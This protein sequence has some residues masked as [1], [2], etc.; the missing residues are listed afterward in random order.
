MTTNMYRIYFKRFVDIVGA[1]VTIV[2]LFPIFL[3]IIALIKI[4]DPGP[5]IFIQRR[6]GKA[7]KVFEFYKFRSM[8]ENIG[9]FP[10]DK[11]GDIK[12]TW[13][14]KLIRRTSI[15]ELPQLINI[16]KGDMSIIGPRPPIPKQEELIELRRLNGALNCR[17]GLTG[18]AQVNSFNGMSV[19]EKASFDAEYAGNIS[20]INDTIIVLKTIMYLFKPPPKY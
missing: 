19:Q 18:L 2:F 3:I 4:V 10:S 15:D 7:G 5:I 20:F 6:V 9:D 17:P 8:P 13:I 1:L 14:G 12:L 11:L 16:I